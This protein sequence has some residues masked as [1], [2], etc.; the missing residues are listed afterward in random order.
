MDVRNVKEQ[1]SSFDVTVLVREWQTLVGGRIEKVYH[2]EKDKLCF[3]ISL[4]ESGKTYLHVKAG[5]WAC[6]MPT[7]EAIETEPT[8]FAMSLRKYIANGR[9]AEIS[10]L[11][12]DRIVSISVQKEMIYRVILEMFGKGNV[13]LT[14]DE[15]M[16]HL[17]YVETWSHRTLKRGLPYKQ[18]PQ[19]I[20]IHALTFDGLRDLRE[21]KQNAEKGVVQLLASALNLGGLYSEEICLK[22]GLDKRSK[23][24]K[25]TDMELNS[26]YNTIRELAD[27]AKRPGGYV[28][29]EKGPVTVLPHK[30]L[31]YEGKEHI[32]FAS[33]NEAVR[34]YLEH[35]PEER[36]KSKTDGQK[37][38]VLR[39]IAQQEKYIKE[40]QSE[41]QE[42]RRKAEAI[43]IHQT[44]IENIF[45]QIRSGT[46]E[47]RDEVIQELIGSNRIVSWN[48][49]KGEVTFDVEGTTLQLKIAKTLHQ[50]VQDYY[51]K[52]KKTR[53]KLAGAMRAY[54]NTKNRL[55][56]LDRA[57]VKGVHE[58]G[59]KRVEKELWFERHRWLITSGCNLVIGGKDASSNERVVKRYMKDGDR[60]CHGDVHGA[61]S[62]VVKAGPSGIGRETLEE[63]CAFSLLF[64]KAW[65]AGI[66]SGN[67]YWV[68][69]DQ[70]SKTPTS[71]EFVPRGG[72]I[73]RG[74]RNYVNVEM[75]A[76]IGIIDEARWSEAEPLLDSQFGTLW[77]RLVGKCM[78]GPMSAVKRWCKRYV[79]FEP[80][81]EEKTRFAEKVS[82]FMGISPSRII[83]LLPPGGARLITEIAQ[84]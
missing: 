67:A 52:A 71:G 7:G 4:P 2:T 53:E 66:G 38:H 74:K 22:T 23:V 84:S 10:Q 25:L 60:Y 75:R 21:Q 29:I 28:V 80:G 35:R 8:T 44:A 16:L 14:D 33:F 15:K 42:L 76:A 79:V 12:F 43:Y 9:I 58:P 5:S 46:K 19:T 27:T 48:R 72:F 50:N 32:E 62:V 24:N 51:A 63:A 6:L 77:S 68:T 39:Q 34:Y 81:K 56:E 70:V 20:D 45:Q 13:I 47:R 61:P 55:S 1:L 17:L 83:P 49:A 37:E 82:G 18:P 41:I 59:K 11:G 64:S 3:K 40:F 57:L 54:E 31:T 69:P 73:I 65:N 78:C 36:E 26:I 30:L